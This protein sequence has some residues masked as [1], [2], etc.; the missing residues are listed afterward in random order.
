M[1]AHLCAGAP[2]YYLVIGLSACQPSEEQGRVMVPSSASA[3]GVPSAARYLKVAATC[4]TGSSHVSP[5]SAPQP[6]KFG[7]WVIQDAVQFVYVKRKIADTVVDRQPDATAFILRIPSR[8]AP[9]KFLRFL[10]TSRHVL[11]PSWM[12]CPDT[13]PKNDPHEIFVRFNKPQ[14]GTSLEELALY[15]DRGRPLAL[16]PPDPSV[17][18][19]ALLLSR[20][21]VPQIDTYVFFDLPFKNLAT[22]EEVARLT[23]GIPLMT[24][25]LLPDFPG[26]QRNYPIFRSGTLSNTP[27]EPISVACSDRINERNVHVWLIDATLPPGASGAP[28]F[29]I[30]DRGAGHH[31]IPA[32]V[33]IQSLSWQGQGVA[34]M[35][36]VTD[37]VALM[38]SAAQ[39]VDLDFRRGL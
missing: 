4:D 30:E 34:A 26:S 38:S 33:G 17:D 23:T 35:T 36:P 22:D 6:R 12:G 20:T 2:L 13:P 24:A 3:E 29:T 14:G 27:D 8:K 11:Q 16:Y 5:P 7:P 39:G 37:L 10:I 32:L 9:E 19:A 1:R 21:K 18:L 15:D 28:V 25:G 31:R